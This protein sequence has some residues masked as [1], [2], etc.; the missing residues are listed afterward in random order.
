MKK[1][2]GFILFLGLFGMT[3]ICAQG[4]EIEFCSFEELGQQKGLAM[5]PTFPGDGLY[6]TA[7]GELRV[8]I[9]F[10]RFPGD[11]LNL[12]GWWAP[13]DDPTILNTIIDANNSVGSTELYNLTHFFKEMSRSDFEVVGDA[14]SVVAPQTE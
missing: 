3:N 12:S 9:V 14:I 5:Q 10:V 2:L 1:K 8:L 4:N 11:T 7:N 13:D 6:L